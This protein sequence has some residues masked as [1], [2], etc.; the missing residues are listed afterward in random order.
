MTLLA[1]WPWAGG[2]SSIAHRI[3]DALGDV[4]NFVEPLCGSA[5]VLLAR[6]H[7]PHTETVNDADGFV[8]NAYRAIQGEPEVVATWAD[9]PVS[10][11]D[12]HARHHWLNT[13]RAHLTARL[14]GDPDYYDAKVAGW[15]IW[16]A[17][18]WIGSGWCSGQG[19]WHVVDGA[20]V[21]GGDAG[22]GIHRKLPH[23]GD[24]GRGIH[25]QLPHLGNAGQGIRDYLQAIA[26]RLRR[27]RITCGPWER[28]LV[29]SITY[30]HGRTGIFLDPPYREDEHSFGYS[31]GS[32]VW[33]NC[34]GWALA[35]GSHPGLRIVLAGYDDGRPLP[36]G[37]SLVRWKARGGYG[38]QGHGRGRDNCQ[39]E[40]LYL[41]PHCLHEEQSLP[42]FAVEE[43]L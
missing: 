41:S 30:R 9:W 34:W 17:C 38:S 8:V 25:R 36:A 29:P 43:T 40:C 15:W 11:C 13:Q 10:E 7:P 3:W 5:A 12:L 39:R 23:L 28:I 42:L 14:E 26:T 4:P 35:H 21:N 27:V 20:L 2:K 6:P 37:W 16:G 22:R 1:P 32:N 18:S 31:G 33:D 24:A 19:P